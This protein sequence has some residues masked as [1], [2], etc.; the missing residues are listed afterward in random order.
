M[1]SKCFREIARRSVKY[2]IVTCS[3]ADVNMLD[4]VERIY[5]GK[6]KEKK[7]KNTLNIATRCRKGANRMQFDCLNPSCCDVSSLTVRT[8]VE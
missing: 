4:C 5:V 6:R 7:N 2:Y 3:L 8:L 1:Q